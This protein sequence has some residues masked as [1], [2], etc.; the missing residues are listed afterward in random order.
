MKSSTKTNSI[1]PSPLQLGLPR[2]QRIWI[3][4][5]FILIPLALAWFA[6]S[7]AARSQLPAPPPDGGYP[8][9]NTAEGDGALVSLTT[10]FF[11]TATGSFALASN[12]TGGSNTATGASALQKN[13]DGFENTATGVLAL[14][15]NTTGSSNTATGLDALYSNTT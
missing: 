15:S 10:G 14:F 3:I 11:N 6:L 4:R 5:G 7:P 2:V 8:N 12:T 9:G 13:T 1:H